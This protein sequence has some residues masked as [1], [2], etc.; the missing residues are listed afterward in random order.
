MWALE[1][2]PPAPCIRLEWY[3]TFGNLLPR[4]T[5][6]LTPPHPA[7]VPGAECS[8][9]FTI[10]SLVS[11]TSS[12]KENTGSCA[13]TGDISSSIT[14]SS[15]VSALNCVFQ[16]DSNSVTN[17]QLWTDVWDNSGGACTGL[18]PDAY[19]KLMVDSYSIYGT[20]ANVSAPQTHAPVDLLSCKPMPRHALKAPAL[21]F[22]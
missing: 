7:I 5:L 1:P 12:S 16:D 8:D 20:A 14:D 9:A 3:A 10:N 19:F 17:T 15:V 11:Y 6:F 18:S 21:V 13:S 4:E 22:A 2:A